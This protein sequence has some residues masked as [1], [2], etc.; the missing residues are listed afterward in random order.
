[1]AVPY[2]KGGSQRRILAPVGQQARCLEL[3]ISVAQI[4]Q[5]QR[6]H[7]GDS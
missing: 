5:R 6:D 1:M 4:E 7:A 3:C 2:D